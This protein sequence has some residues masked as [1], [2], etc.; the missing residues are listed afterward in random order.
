L[1]A[2]RRWRSKPGRFLDQNLA[3]SLKD[4]LRGGQSRLGRLESGYKALV[5]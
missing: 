4:T 2:R 1:G 3:G 5:H